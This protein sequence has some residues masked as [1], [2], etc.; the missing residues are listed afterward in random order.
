MAQQEY[1][2]YQKDVISNYYKNLDV[3]MLQKLGVLVSELYLADSQSKIEK[4]WQRVQKAMIK[5]KIPYPV[6][7]HIMEK[8]DVQ[9]LARNLQE[10]Q[11]KSK[12]I[13]T[14]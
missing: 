7:N 5:L 8:K 9:I 11:S 13:R 10:W 14:R 12:K 6:V 2:D 4:L 3:I 1:S